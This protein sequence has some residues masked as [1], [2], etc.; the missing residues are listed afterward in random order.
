MESKI[1]INEIKEPLNINII[2]AIIKYKKKIYKDDDGYFLCLDDTLIKT[3]ITGRL[4]C[5]DFVVMYDLIPWRKNHKSVEENKKRWN[6]Y[7]KKIKE[8][9]SS[10]K[11]IPSK[12]EDNDFFDKIYPYDKLKDELID[13]DDLYIEGEEGFY[14][15]REALDETEKRLKNG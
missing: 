4:K 2:K 1:D 6:E 9:E 12:I 15:Y 11:L 7:Y 13:F 8:L 3:H 10:G 5:K 14:T